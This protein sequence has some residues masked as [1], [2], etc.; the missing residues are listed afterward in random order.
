MK[1]LPQQK[2]KIRELAEISTE[3]SAACF[4]L[5]ELRRE[6]VE[7]LQKAKL[8]LVKRQAYLDQVKQRVATTLGIDE[9]LGKEYVAN[10]QEPVDLQL[11]LVT[12]LEVSIRRIEERQVQINV[13][14]GVA[15]VL[16]EK[17]LAYTGERHEDFPG[18]EFSSVGGPRDAGSYVPVSGRG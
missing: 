15:S 18:A 7:L 16:V 9:Q 13:K 17:L 10:A 12:A 11:S 5:S 4:G 14:S 6:K 3:L 8:E 2:R 1:L